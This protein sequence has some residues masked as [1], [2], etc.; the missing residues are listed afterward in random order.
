MYHG[1]Q[2]FKP[3]E[4]FNLRNTAGSTKTNNSAADTSTELDFA[5]FANY[6]VQYDAIVKLQ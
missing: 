5:Q 4:Y 2:F 3:G 6:F 1:H